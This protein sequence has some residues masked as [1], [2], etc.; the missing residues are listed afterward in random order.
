MSIFPTHNEL[1]IAANIAVTQVLGLKKDEGFLIITNPE[2][3]V[4][5]ISMALYNA[6]VKQGAK[7]VLVYQQQKS[8]LDFAEES[9]I[10]AIHKAPAVVVSMSANKLGKD[11]HAL[12]KPFDHKG[13]KFDHVFTYYLR[14]NKSIR[15]FW[16]PGVT[17]DIFIRT[18]PID[19]PRLREE[20][21]SIKIIIDRATGVRVTAPAGT[22]LYIGLKG[23]KAMK[24]DGEFSQP[25]SGGNVPCGEV[26]ASPALGTSKGIIAFDGSI[27]LFDKTILINEPIRCT[28]SDGF[29]VDISG[30]EEADGLADTISKGRENAK[31]MA[32]EGKL[33]ADKK[34]EYMT[35]ASNLGELGIGLNPKATI[36][37][38][39]LEDEKAYRT[40]HI[41]IGSN[42]DGDANALIHL[43]GLIKEPTITAIFEDGSEQV[44]V[45]DGDLVL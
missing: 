1:E 17:K 34:E 19:Y 35:N 9:V 24:D 29:V 14:G 18:V 30:G 2:E 40:C 16:S 39:M 37:G 22:D 15:S 5:Q 13:K 4:S 11:I 42:Y 43:D 25:G 26:F 41:A 32:E 36:T 44:F 7:P 21:A 23:R 3:D 12:E 45:K 27:S 28:I 38:N 20:A 33:P 8:Q 31:S 6:A 10:G